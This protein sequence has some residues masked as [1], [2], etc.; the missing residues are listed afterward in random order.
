MGVLQASIKI[1][2]DGS[3]SEC[4]RER[5]SNNHRSIRSQGADGTRHAE[6]VVEEDAD[7]L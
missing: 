3:T 1:T 6:R 5:I 4:A 2:T 7:F